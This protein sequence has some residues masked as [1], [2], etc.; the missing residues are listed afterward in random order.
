MFLKNK[1][2]CQVYQV[3]IVTSIKNKQE[4]LLCKLKTCP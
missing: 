3:T 4:D 1:R 2:L